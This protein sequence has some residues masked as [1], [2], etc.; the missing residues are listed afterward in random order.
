MS[1]DDS[2]LARRKY[3][4]VFVSDI[5]LGARHC[6]AELLVEFLQLFETEK[7][8]LV[9]DIVDGWR[10]RKSWYWPRSHAEVLDLILEKGRMGADVFYTPGNH[11][12]STRKFLGRRI[13]NVQVVDQV[14]HE[15]ANGRRYL[16]VHGDKFDVVVQNAKWLAY[17]GDRFYAFALTTNTWLNLT[18][19]W[20]GL[21]YWSL[22]GFAKRHVKSFVSLIGRYESRVVEQVRQHEVQGVIC[23]HIH[24]AEDRT[25][26]GI[27]YINSGDWVE[28]C[29]AI[30]EHFDGRL[31]VIYWADLARTKARN[32]ILPVGSAH[33]DRGS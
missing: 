16:V 15:C 32:P 25:V 21:G 14:I 6:Q 30:V 7:L 2:V 3:R 24:H 22:G 11:D 13:K 18:R 29:T 23:G 26:N 19:R 17:L 33:E 12:E 9:G 5:H 10:L 8:Y 28:S 31:E 27:H 20:C 1:V 4:S